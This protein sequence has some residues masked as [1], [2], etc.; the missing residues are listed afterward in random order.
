M[1]K[2]MRS[3]V[4]LTNTTSKGTASKLPISSSTNP[5]STYRKLGEYGEYGV[6]MRNIKTSES[7]EQLRFE[8]GHAEQGILR[9]TRVTIKEEYAKDVDEDVLNPNAAWNKETNV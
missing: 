6:E 5:A 8:N 9:T 7:T 3:V 2:A 4:G 1:K